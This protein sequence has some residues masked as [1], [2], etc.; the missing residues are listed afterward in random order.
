MSISDKSFLERLNENPD[1]FEF[2]QD[3][4]EFCKDIKINDKEYFVNSL[5]IIFKKIKN[6]GAGYAIYQGLR[7]LA[8]EKPSEAIQIIELIEEKNNNEYLNFISSLLGGLSQS[9]SKYTYKDKILTLIKSEEEAKINSGVNAAYQVVI[10]NKQEELKFI[11]EVS[12]NIIQTIEKGNVEDLGIIARFYNKHLNNLNDAKKM[13]VQLLNTKKVEVQSEVARSINAEFNFDEDPIHFKTC[14]KLLTH[15]DSKY[16]GIYNTIN[17]RL[18]DTIKKQPEVVTEFVNLWILNN[19]VNL[20]GITVL[21]EIIEELY[22]SNPHTIESLFLEWLNSDNSIYKAALQFVISD[23][24]NHVDAVGLPKDKLEKFTETDA[25]YVVFMIVG[26]IL[27]RKYAS[28][29]LYNILEVHFNNERIR[30]HIATLYAKYLII[31][32]YSVTDILKEKRKT[33]NP[34][35]TSI[36]DQIIEVSEQYYKQVTDLEVVNEFEPSDKRMTYFLKQQNK[37]MQELMDAT[38]NKRSSFLDFATKISLKAGK[39]FFSK[40]NGKYTEESEMQNFRSSVEV[41]RVQ[42]IDEIGQI[43]SRIMWQNMKRNEL[44]N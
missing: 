40:Y 14:L 13:V 2:W 29:M 42:Y 35:I 5:P 15:T 38:E 10:S 12:Q 24:S 23:L 18:K 26:N 34:I 16:I 43:K 36:I 3:F 33:A 11:N 1:Y 32:Y 39:S 19:K 31:N 22:T 37:Q 17:F 30:N 20:K 21:K 41:A 9:K 4:H 27:D 44:P 25:L 28:E 6:D 8:V 7:K